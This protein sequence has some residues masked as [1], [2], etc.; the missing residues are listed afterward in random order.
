M[1]QTFGKKENKI[2]GLGIKKRNE[3][4]ENL[5]FKQCENVTKSVF[6]S[7]QLCIMHQVNETLVYSIHCRLIPLY[8]RF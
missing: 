6:N 3:K 8:N 5:N 4:K 2:F 7:L 1:K